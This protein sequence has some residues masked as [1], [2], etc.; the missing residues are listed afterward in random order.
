M[1]TIG[2]TGRTMYTC[3]SNNDVCL[4]RL[5]R[6]PTGWL[7]S[8]ATECSFPPT[9]RPRN[10]H[11]TISGFLRYQSFHIRSPGS[12]H[13]SIQQRRLLETTHKHFSQWC[14]TFFG[15]GPLI[16]LWI[17]SG[18]KQVSRP[19]LGECLSKQYFI[20]YYN[21]LLYIIWRWCA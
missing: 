1:C 10:S 11:Q 19:K 5:H 3:R 15:H 17:S 6:P 9:D 4:V 14:T 7:L 13:Q 16:D 2:S 20:I 12:H 18:A 8:S 21:I